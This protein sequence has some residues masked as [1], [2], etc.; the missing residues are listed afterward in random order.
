MDD[1]IL[2]IKKNYL[3]NTIGSTTTSWFLL[4]LNY[5][6][7]TLIAQSP[8]INNGNNKPNIEVIVFQSIII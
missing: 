5:Y 4:K 7:P 3:N 6:K 2:V 1:C 8:K